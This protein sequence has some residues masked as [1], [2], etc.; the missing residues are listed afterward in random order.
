MSEIDG[1]HGDHGE[2]AVPVS[3]VR[4]ADHTVERRCVKTTRRRVCGKTFFRTPESAAAIRAG[5]IHDLC[6]ACHTR[7]I[8]E[9]GVL[10][11]QRVST[12]HEEQSDDASA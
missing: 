7:S 8:V 1:Q 11:G 2:Q 12:Q 4:T 5:S 6:P 9:G 10:G 3:P